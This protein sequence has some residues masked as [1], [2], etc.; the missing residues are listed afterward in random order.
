MWTASPVL[1]M[2]SFSPRAGIRGFDTPVL[3]MWTASPVLAMPSFSPRAG[4]RGFDTKMSVAQFKAAVAGKTF[5]SPSG[6]S[7]L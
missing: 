4:I 1:A 5:Q 3:A 6:D 7:W 2:P